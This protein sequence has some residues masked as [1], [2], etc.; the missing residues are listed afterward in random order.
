MITAPSSTP[1]RD[2]NKD[3]LDL[4]ADSL[5]LPTGPRMPFR[6]A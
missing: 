2:D 3:L 5:S 4:S 6:T 1:A